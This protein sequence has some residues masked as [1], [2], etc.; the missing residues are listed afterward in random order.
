MSIV[1]EKSSCENISKNKTGP[2]KRKKENTKTDEKLITLLDGLINVPNEED[3]CEL[4]G[5]QISKKMRVIP[6]EDREEM[7]IKILQLFLQQK[8]RSIIC[9]VMVM[10][11]VNTLC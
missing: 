8:K 7:Q 5:K 2:Y 3:E 10:I 6:E 1:E 11:F 9:I 4:F